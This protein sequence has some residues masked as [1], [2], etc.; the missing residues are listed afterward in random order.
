MDSTSTEIWIESLDG[1]PLHGRRW[2]REGAT[3]GIGIV[4]GLGDHSG[5][6]ERVARTLGAR[7]FLVEALDLPG[8][9]RSPGARGHARS[10]QEYRDAMTSWIGRNRDAR[11]DLPWALLGQ[12][13]GA[14]IALDWSLANPSAI[15]ALVLCAPP[16]ELALRPSMLKVYAAQAVV[17]FW[18]RFSQGT[19]IA[20]SML[21]H[22]PEVVRAHRSDPLVH[23]RMSAR[24]F[25]E[26]QTVR[27]ALAHRARDVAV[28]TFVVQGAADPVTRASGTARWARAV[29][30][31]RAVYREYPG[32]LH[33]VLNEPEGPAVLEEIG[34]WL[35]GVL[36]RSGG[37][38]RPPALNR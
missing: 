2:E 3:A 30:A 12:S 32:L 7:G 13:M 15:R 1:S 9:G 29:G 24:L 35:E 25:L 8:H 36:P 31:G 10:W 27:H 26:F 20:P 38:A 6:Y 37:D 14:L 34:R 21:S 18:P 16:F 28:P 5:R 19:A 33:E 23:Y 17:R 22:D 11:P 4:H